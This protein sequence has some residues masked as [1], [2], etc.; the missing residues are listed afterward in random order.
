MTSFPRPEHAINMDRGD[1]I[2]RWSPNKSRDEF[3]TINL[4]YRTLVLH[5][6]IGKIQPGGG[7]ENFEY[8]D[9]S[10]HTDFQAFGAYDWSPVMPGHDLPGLL[11]VGSKGGDVHLLRIDDD[12]SDFITLPLKT[13]RACHAVAFNA[14]GLLAVGLDK[15][16]NDHC[17][18]IW[19]INHRLAGWDPSKTGLQ[20]LPSS[21]EPYI[22]LELNSI[23]SSTRWFEDQPQTLV[24]G[25]KNQSLRMHDLRGLCRSSWSA[26]EA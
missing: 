23:I 21:A 6:A 25:V 15:V 1:G 7:P 5:K 22:K 18:Q 13:P 10:T 14:T 4:N 12:S 8:E 17:L 2:I 11:A 9:N 19:D 16:R 3:L 20:N 26:S 24:V